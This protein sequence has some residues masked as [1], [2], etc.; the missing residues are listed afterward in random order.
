MSER[1]E[2]GDGSVIME[3]YLLKWTNYMKGFQQRYFVLDRG[4]LSYYRNSE[5][6]NSTCR[7]TMVLKDA[8]IERDIGTNF[9]VTQGDKKLTTTFHLRAETERS[10]SQ[11][12]AALEQAK[13]FFTTQVGKEGTLRTRRSSRINSTDGEG[14]GATDSESEE[15]HYSDEESIVDPTASRVLSA[16]LGNLQKNHQQLARAS[17]QLKS[18]FEALSGGAI[19]ELRQHIQTLE[20]SAGA[21]VNSSSE[22][23]NEVF[24]YQ[25]K[26][27]KIF[28]LNETKRKHLEE[29]LE[30]LAREHAS[31]ARG[32]TRVKGLLADK[33]ME[34]LNLDGSDDEFYDANDEEDPDEYS[35]AKTS[36]PINPVPAVASPAPGHARALST[37][38]AIIAN[39]AAAPL[40]KPEKL[41]QAMK[42]FRPREVITFKPNK[43]MS[44]WGVMKNC[45]G[46]DL[47]KI[48][49]PVH[50]N[51]PLSF[52]QRIVE[53]LEYA[54][55][56]SQAARCKTSVERMIYVAAFTVSSFANVVLRTGKPF[57]PLLGETYEFDSMHNEGWKAVV[58]QVSHHP[59]ICALHSEHEDWVFWQEFEMNSKFRGAYLEIIPVGISHLILKASGDHYTWTKVPTTVHNIIVGKLWADQHGTMVITNHVTGDKCDLKYHAYSY[60]ASI[61]PRSVDATVTDV[62]GAVRYKLHG[63]WDAYMKAWPANDDREDAKL[64]VWERRPVHAD[65]TRMYGFTGMSCV[66]NEKRPVDAGCA[67]TDSRLRPDVR[68]MEEAEWE[69][70][71]DIKGQ[72]EDSQRK[73]RREMEK[74]MQLWQPVWFELR[75]DPVIPGREVH[76]YKG[77]YWE[78]KDKGDW[79]NITNIYELPAQ[80]SRQ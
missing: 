6:R 41:Q 17:Q 71:N 1:R 23:L 11:W 55:L 50:F 12:I 60:F 26:W 5:E 31:L 30:Q 72:L 37:G 77:G 2:Q 53:D 24:I 69:R 47:S 43:K 14:D 61:E 68:L 18:K 78:A 32:A 21:L 39:A 79:Q 57:N 15:E 19:S 27:S 42:K 63:T 59:P 28:Q 70:A 66:L 45:I 58:E 35:D 64:R 48:P 73:R 20:T 46:K 65:A 54:S 44:L 13:L 36:P 7:G 75:P 16:K 9:A 49:M 3:G 22:Y 76:Q 25:K 10:K 74:S 40:S 52:T 8:K 62:S 29:Q 80:T 67:P 33:A 56:L 4:I 51:E 38:S 34:G